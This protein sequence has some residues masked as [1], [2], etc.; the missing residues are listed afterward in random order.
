MR[1]RS[2]SGAGGLRSSASAA[3]KTWTPVVELL[4]V[5]RMAPSAG[6]KVL[7]EVA[8]RLMMMFGAGALT[9]ATKCGK[10][11]FSRLTKVTQ[12]PSRRGTSPATS[13]AG[14][15]TNSGKSGRLW[16]APF[17]CRSVDPDAMEDDRDLARDRDLG[18]LHGDAFDQPHPPCLEG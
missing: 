13:C 6:V 7:S 11:A 1:E 17:E 8:K 15:C 12:P 16:L 4:I 3:M 5:R 9:C 18:F 2:P 10:T 14:D